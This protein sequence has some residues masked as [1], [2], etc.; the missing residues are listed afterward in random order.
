MGMCSRCPFRS[1]VKLFSF[2]PAVMLVVISLNLTFF[3]QCDSVLS[4]KKVY[5]DYL[6]LLFC[7]FVGVKTQFGDSLRTSDL[8]SILF[9]FSALAYCLYAILTLLANK[10]L[11]L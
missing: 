6:G 4:K 10:V 11:R 7:F 1:R 5:F 9:I 3:L 8:P 2:L